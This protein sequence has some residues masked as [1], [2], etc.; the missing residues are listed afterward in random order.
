MINIYNYLDYREWLK[1]IVEDKKKNNTYFS[2]RLL[3]EKI[4]LDSSFIIKVI[5]GKRNLSPASVNSIADYF[6]LTPNEKD[7]FQ[8]LLLF[9]KAKNSEQ[10]H[11]LYDELLT[12]RNSSSRIIIA[13]QYEFYSK[14]YYNALRNLLQIYKFKGKDYKELGKKLSPNITA[15]EARKGI[16]LLKKLKLIYF[17]EEG[18]YQLTEL[19]VTAG[20]RWDSYAI[21]N[22]QMNN[23][24]LGKE[25]IDRFDKETR[26][27]S[28][29]T[30]NVGEKDLPKI[31]E[32]VTQFRKELI[33]YV[34]NN[35]NPER[36]YHLNLQFF[37][38]SEEIKQ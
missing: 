2:Y 22:F 38:F 8:N 18:Y 20:S 9:A 12:L 32:M 24:D 28:C 23:I 21:R 13:D 7:Y 11:K 3:A 27:V 4:D 15:T 33:Q 10:K 6:E 36:V 37:P 5:M 25:A 16:H 26:D 30:M 19:A 14:W 35:A 17:S 34:N 29:I 1:D 31:K